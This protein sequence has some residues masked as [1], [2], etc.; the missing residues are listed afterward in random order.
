[1][2]T[3]SQLK[4]NIHTPA[5]PSLTPLNAWVFPVRLFDVRP[6]SHAAITVFST[7]GNL[8]DVGQSFFIQLP[9]GAPKGLYH[10]TVKL[11]SGSGGYLLFSRLT[12][13]IKPTRRILHESDIITYETIQ[14]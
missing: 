2:K 5:L 4:I 8:T 6:E 11:Q 12:P 10:F 13:G 9:E 3:G 7:Q 14:N 1:S